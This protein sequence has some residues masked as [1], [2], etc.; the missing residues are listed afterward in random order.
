MYGWFIIFNEIQTRTSLVKLNGFSRSMNSLSV[1]IINVI[2]AEKHAIQTSRILLNSQL[3]HFDKT[4]FLSSFT[5]DIEKGIMEINW[6]STTTSKKT[7]LGVLHSIPSLAE[8]KKNV[9]EISL[10]DVLTNTSHSQS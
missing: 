6:N 3:L 8:G 10:N 2:R 4:T 5:F 1:R 7:H 9:R